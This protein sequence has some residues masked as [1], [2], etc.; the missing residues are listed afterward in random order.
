M[1]DTRIPAF[2][3]EF[4]RFGEWPAGADKE[5]CRRRLLLMY[6]EAR[7]LPQLANHLFSEF[8]RQMGQA[9]ESKESGLLPGYDGALQKEDLLKRLGGRLA[10]E[11]FEW[12]CTA[13]EGDITQMFT[14]TD[15]NST[16]N[17]SFANSEYAIE[18]MTRGTTH[19]AV[20]FADLGGL[21]YADIRGSVAKGPLLWVGYDSS[22]YVVAKSLV[23]EE[24]MASDSSAQCVVQACYSAAWSTSTETAFRSAVE[25][26]LSGPPSP[27][28]IPH[29]PMTNEVMRLLRHWHAAASVPLRAARSKWMASR[30]HT[31]EPAAACR[32]RCDRLALCAYELT[33]QLGAATAGSLAMFALP[34]GVEVAMDESILQVGPDRYCLPRH[35][36]VI[37]PGRYCSPCHRMP[38]S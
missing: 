31:S 17:H 6:E 32:V 21:L 4:A 18:A 22:A 15:Y 25:A 9:A 7:A 11:A 30:T 33:G 19:V 10:E 13:P 5:A 12:W 35:R 24:M 16:I 8:G 26:C 36:H 2:N 1:V 14:S 3:T 27:P 28:G 38:F 29:V 23:I 20:G 37:E 34:A